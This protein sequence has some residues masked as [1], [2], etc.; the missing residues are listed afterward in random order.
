MAGYRCD[1]LLVEDALL[2]SSSVL[3]TLRPSIAA[4]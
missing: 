4:S 3:A 2:N 1:R